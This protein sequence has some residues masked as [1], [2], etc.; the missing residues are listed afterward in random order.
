MNIVGLQSIIYGV[1]DVELATRFQ[2]DWG[3]ELV[4]KGKTGSAFRLP[5]DTSVHIRSVD[6][7]NLPPVPGPPPQ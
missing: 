1:E 6:D 7:D 5:D 4:E 2:E 3:L